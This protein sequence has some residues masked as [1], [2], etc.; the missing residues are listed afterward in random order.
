MGHFFKSLATIS[1]LSIIACTPILL[2]LSPASAIGSTLLAQVNE[3]NKAK[4]TKI[5]FLI[6]KLK[7]DNREERE[8]ILERLREIGE[9]AVPTLIKALK[10]PDKRVRSGACNALGR[11]YQ[12]DSASSKVSAVVSNL[13][14]ALKDSEVQV[15]RSAAFALSQMPLSTLV[16]ESKTITPGIIAA[17][18][19]QDRDVRIFAVLTLRS[20]SF[21]DESSLAVPELISALKDPD[22]DVRNLAAFALSNV[23]AVPAL[24]KALQD[25]NKDVRLQVIDILPGLYPK[26]EQILPYLRDALKDPDQDVRHHAAITLAL[27]G[28]ETYSV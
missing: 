12:Q 4:D 27:I 22:M 9:E 21:A 20:R 10:D 8:K 24:I 7:T 5:A 26:Q 28:E 17:L 16:A 18:K 14:V 11:I 19:D 1:A 6:E 13:I 3:N 25:P 15:R 23:N 2:S